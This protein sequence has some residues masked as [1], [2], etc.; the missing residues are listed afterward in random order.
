MIKTFKCKETEKIWLGEF[1]KKFPRPIQKMVRRKLRMLNQA[2]SVKDLATP[3]GNKLENLLGDRKGQY[4]IRA[5]QQYRICF[6]F[7]NGNCYNVHLV[8]YH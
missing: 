7:V 6:E 8:D 3:P 2:L 1:S 4:S 5:N